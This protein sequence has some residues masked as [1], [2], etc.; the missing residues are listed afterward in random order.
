MSNYVYIEIINKDTKEVV[1][2]IDVSNKAAGTMTRIEAGVNINLNHDRFL[3]D[4]AWY[5]HK[6]EQKG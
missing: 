6:Q 3:T 4:I 5:D 2:R 1:K